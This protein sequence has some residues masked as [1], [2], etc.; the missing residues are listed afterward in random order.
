MAIGIAYS[1]ALFLLLLIKSG[2]CL[3][4]SVFEILDQSRLQAAYSSNGVLDDVRKL[5]MSN[6][7]SVRVASYL[8]FRSVTQL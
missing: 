8:H 5:A 7:S 3:M 2:L 1:C 4:L 6:Y